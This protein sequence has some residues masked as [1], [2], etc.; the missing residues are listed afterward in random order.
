MTWSE[1]RIAGNLPAGRYEVTL[2]SIGNEIVIIGGSDDSS[3]VND[4]YT[5]TTGKLNSKN[6]LEFSLKFQYRSYCT[7]M[8]NKNSS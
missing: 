6:I 3:T 7:T 5:L 2:N 1:Q 8:V 4:I